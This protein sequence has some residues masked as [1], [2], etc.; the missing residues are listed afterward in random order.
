MEFEQILIATLDNS[1]EIREQAEF[2]INQYKEKD[3]QHFLVEITKNILRTNN[4]ISFYISFTIILQDIRSGKLFADQEL[5]D[6]FLSIFQDVLKQIFTMQKLDDPTCNILSIILT[7][8]SLKYPSAN[9]DQ[10]LI[11]LIDE[12]PE[13]QSFFINALAT[14]LFR[15]TNN[16]PFDVFTSILSLPDSSYLDYNSKIFLVFSIIEHFPKNTDELY[17]IISQYISNIPNESIQY[18][19]FLFSRYFQRLKKFFEDFYED[20]FTFIISCIENY[21]DELPIQAEAVDC[22][23]NIAISYKDS[24]E[25]ISNILLVILQMIE[26][27]KDNEIESILKESIQTMSGNIKSWNFLSA[28]TNI[29]DEKKLHFSYLIA[30]SELHPDSCD[31]LMLHPVEYFTQISS[32]YEDSTI[33]DFFRVKMAAL[34]AIE[35]LCTIS[36]PTFQEENFDSLFEIIHFI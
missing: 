21:Q 14:I 24:D 15:S 34:L 5:F 32:I 31:Q 26:I 29:H 22:L 11:S 20:I 16:T 25:I 19:L 33:D 7:K 18:V 23:T 12:T 9:I 8:I 13:L 27:N 17:S 3:Y 36:G 10:F 35:N 2:I 4:Q 28:L 6:F 1:N 30:I